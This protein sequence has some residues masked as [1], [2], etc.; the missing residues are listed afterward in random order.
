MH[1]LFHELARLR[2]RGLP[3]SLV[4]AGAGNGLLLRHLFIPPFDGVEWRSRGAVAR[5]LMPDFD[6]DVEP[7]AR[8]RPA[9][10]L[11]ELGPCF[12]ES[13]VAVPRL[14]VVASLPRP[15]DHTPVR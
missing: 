10:E 13:R 15:D 3:P 11:I 4:L 14:P 2:R 1:L 5:P 9:D 12:L 8:F 6:N 7:Q